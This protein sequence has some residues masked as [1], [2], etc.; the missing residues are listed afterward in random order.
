MRIINALAL[1][2]LASSSVN[3][4]IISGPFKDKAECAAFA[5]L[6][7][8]DNRITPE[9]KWAMY[10]KTLKEFAQL[11]QNLL[12]TSRF[13]TE[14]NYEM[15]IATIRATDM[16]NLIKGERENAAVQLWNKYRCGSK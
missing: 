5:T 13:I 1:F 2:L 16:V 7:G 9:Q 4:E 11:R 10:D 3:A 14:Y 8:Y 12:G 15:N 6:S